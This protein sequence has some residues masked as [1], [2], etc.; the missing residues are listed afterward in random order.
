MS[1]GGPLSVLVAAIGNPNRGDDGVGPAVADRLRGRVPAGV[2]VIERGGDVLGVIE[3]WAG[4]SAVL[5]VDA[6]APISRPG[7][8][9]RLDL[10]GQ[11]P[12]VAFAR[13]STH[14]FGIAEAVGLARSLGRL[15]RHLILYLV[16]GE[17]FDIGAPMSP[18]VSDA[19]DRVAQTI[20]AELSRRR[21]A[22][23]K[24]AGEHA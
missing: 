16:E 12:L 4:F 13:G 1:G 20:L 9:H 10:H 2:R 18:A 7:R 3:E 19:V 23:Q 6:A 15:P 21:A 24:G 8:I 17:R 11:S 14:A 22:L 5:V